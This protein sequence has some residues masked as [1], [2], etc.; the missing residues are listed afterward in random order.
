MAFHFVN[1]FFSGLLLCINMKVEENQIRVHFMARLPVQYNLMAIFKGLVGVI[2]EK[3]I[4][5]YFSSLFLK[6]REKPTLSQKS[7][8]VV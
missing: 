3:Y 1:S 2:F 4:S 6:D 8:K 5:I 7:K